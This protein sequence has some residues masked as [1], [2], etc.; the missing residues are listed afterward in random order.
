MNKSECSLGPWREML[1]LQLNS[2]TILAIRREHYRRDFHDFRQKLAKMRKATF[3]DGWWQRELSVVLTSFLADFY[4]GK[5]PKLMIKSPPQHGK[6]QIVIDFLCWVI[7][8]DPRLKTIFASY[9]EELGKRANSE[10][11]KMMLHPEWNDIFPETVMGA[12]EEKRKVSKWRAKRNSSLIQFEHFGGEFRNVTTGGPVTGMSLD[13]GV[14]DDVLKGRADANSENIRNSKWEWFKNDFFTRFSDSA[15]M[16]IIGTNWHVD[17][18]MQRMI[19]AFPD[20]KIVDYPAIATKDEKHRNKGEAL[21]PEHK[22]LEFLLERKNIMEEHEWMSL[23]QQTPT[24]AGGNKF[25][26]RMLNF[27]QMP[28]EFDYTFTISDSSYK[29]KDTADYSVCGHFGVRDGQLYLNDIWRE[30][31]DAADIEVPLAAFIMK[32]KDY[33]YRKTLIEPKGHGIYLNQK[34]T[35]LGLGVPDEEEV[36]KFFK[37]RRLNKV[38]RANNA[39]PHLSDKQLHININLAQE[40]KD[41]IMAEVLQ[42]PSGKHDDIV[43]VIVDGIK[44]AFSSEITIWDSLGR[45]LNG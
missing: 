31:I 23:Y 27:C 1:H 14:I 4:A 34:F 19:T 26:S 24:L 30:Q 44:E 28:D 21:F 9:S 43:D 36:K 8:K 3:K 18:P 33:S 15:G 7:G 42:F 2:E 17:D 10:I 35:K 25:K 39:I 12:D 16:L 45:E 13:L 11:Q 29:E 41:D 20:L 5:R 6:S 22:S 40:I 37:D 38:E 32:H